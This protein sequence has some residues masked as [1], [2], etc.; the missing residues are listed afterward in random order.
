VPEGLFDGATQ[1][2][3]RRSPQLGTPTENVLHAAS[4]LKSQADKFY[5]PDR[6]QEKLARAEGLRVP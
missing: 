4:M 6:N 1:V 3:R 5:A 2:A